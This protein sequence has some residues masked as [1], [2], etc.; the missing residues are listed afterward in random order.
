MHK[1]DD[2]SV[3]YR[4][5]G[6]A[7]ENALIE[8]L[9][10]NDDPAT[11]RH[12][13]PFP[14]T[15]NGAAAVIQTMP[16]DHY[17]GGIL[18]NQIVAI[19]MLRG[20]SEGYSIPSFGLVVDARIRGRGIGRALTRFT[21]ARAP[22]FGVDTIRLSVYASNHQALALYRSLGFEEQ[23]RA[24]IGEGS[25]SDEKI[26]MTKKIVALGRP[27]DT[28]PRGFIPV[29]TPALV[30][31]ERE[32][33]MDCLDSNW[34]SS[35]GSYIGRFE[36]SF[37]EFC[38]VRHSLAC[39]NGTVALH[40]ALL[41]LGI[42]PGDEVLVPTLTYIAS[43]NAV[44]YCG[45]KPVFLDS[46][47]DTWN[48]DPAA[49]EAAIGPRT[50]AILVVHLYGHPA[51]M[52]PILAIAR[53]HGLAIVEDAA[54][55]HGAEY[56]GRRV[57]SFGDVAT[58]SFYG[59]KVITTGE[60]GMVVTNDPALAERM[61]VLR[62][63]GQDLKRRYWFPVVGYNYRMTN[64]EAAIGLAQLEKIDWHLSRR[65]QHAKQ[66]QARLGNLPGLILSPEQPWARNAYWMN[67][68]VLP[69]ELT[70]TRDEVMRQLQLRGVETRPFFYPMHV[71]PPLTSPTLRMASSPLPTGWQHGVL[72]CH[73][74]HYLLKTRSTT[75]ATPSWKS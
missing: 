38:G 54:E 70:V 63:Q 7:D 39:C 19:G 55:A 66:Y 24:V 58:F 22:E 20:W 13:N 65:R 52:E 50:K 60:G 32:Y 59:N 37:A 5:L 17:Y 29:A 16:L 49:L 57:G 74:L 67:C 10:R 43:A 42:G 9:V 35:N 71:L 26:I 41:G 45:A 18:A 62:G 4:E 53:N 1:A 21:L 68:A 6:P 36:T 73:H 34:I 51:D 8:F 56:K 40:L 31:K 3:I 2:Q 28:P 47:P 15:A 61:L 48:I 44:T 14:M 72:I 23:S 25:Q 33:V 64:I 46:E 27:A 30:G 11:T 12:F 75:F 69:I